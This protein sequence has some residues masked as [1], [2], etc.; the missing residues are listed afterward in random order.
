[1]LCFR[2]STWRSNARSNEDAGHIHPDP[3][4][5]MVPIVSMETPCSVT[6]NR[7]AMSST[8]GFSLK[9]PPVPVPARSSISFLCS[10]SGAGG[11]L[12]PMAD[13]RFMSGS[14]SI[15]RTAKPSAAKMR[16]SV[17]ASVVLP[18]PP[19]PVIAIFIVAPLGHEK[20]CFLV[21]QKL[22][23]IE[24]CVKKNSILLGCSL[25]VTAGR[26][27]LLKLAAE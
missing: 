10:V 4:L 26:I 23:I 13:A 22:R 19:L 21:S 27:A 2:S 6:P 17:P 15:A 3:P 9:R 7:Q 14:A 24:L 5:S 8:F 18:T 11:F 1:M 16:A 20:T 25:L 12:I